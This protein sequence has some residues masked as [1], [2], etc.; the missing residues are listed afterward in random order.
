MRPNPPSPWYCLVC[1][2]RV[3]VIRVTR[4][5]LDCEVG[6]LLPVDWVEKLLTELDVHR[7]TGEACEH[8]RGPDR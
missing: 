8:A 4:R 1:R 6:A 3:D 7:A 2:R 5:C